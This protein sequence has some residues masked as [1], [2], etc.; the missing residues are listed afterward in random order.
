MKKRKAILLFV[1]SLILTAFVFEKSFVLAYADPATGVVRDQRYRGPRLKAKKGMFRRRMKELD[2]SKEQKERIRAIRQ[3]HRKEV[4]AEI[5]T[6]LNEEQK[7]RFEEI[8]SEQEI[9]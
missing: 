2:L 5:K 3:K 4:Q 6:V 8:I 7:A 9:Q 1:S